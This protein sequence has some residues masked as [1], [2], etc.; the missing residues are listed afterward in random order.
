MKTFLGICLSFLLMISVIAQETPASNDIVIL[1]NGDRLSGQISNW[2]N[3][4][5]ILVGS[6]IGEVKVP[7]ENIQ[8]IESNRTLYFRTESDVMAAR[9]AGVQN[10]QQV[11]NSGLVGQFSVPREKILM[12]GPTNDSVSP[13]YIKTQNDLKKAQEDLANATQINKVW[14]GFLNLNFSGTSG[15]KDSATFNA[16]AHVERTA[17]SDK[18]IAHL[19]ARYGETDDVLSAKEVSGY[20]RENV[21]ITARLYIYGRLEGKWDE[22]K[23]INF[24]FMAELG[25]GIHILK[26]TDVHLFTDDKITLDFDLGASYSATD[27]KEGEDTHSAGLVARIQY[28]HIFP[29]KWVFSL[30]GT[31]IQDF[32]EPQNKRNAGNLDGYRCILEAMLEMPVTDVLSFTASIKDEYN[33]APAPGLERNDFYWMLGLKLT[34]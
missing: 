30:T 13:E 28:K 6:M 14:S 2:D 25:G 3:G 23:E 21:D 19:E 17:P 31:Y 29:N 26:E 18:F 7:W 27:F 16:I 8:G 10:G 9:P 22:V 34:L 15:N 4:N 12:V 5:V 32:Q 1:K 24:G 11:L 33:N 20:L